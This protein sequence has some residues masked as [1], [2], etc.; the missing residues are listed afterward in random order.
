MTSLRRANRARVKF[1][2][3][4]ALA[5]PR[6]LV[7]DFLEEPAALTGCLPGF[8]EVRILEPGRSYSGSATITW[9][10][11]PL[12]VPIR[13]VWI[14]K[15]PSRG[16]LLRAHAQ[17]SGV[18]VGGEG[19]LALHDASGGGT[20]LQW[21]LTLTLPEQFADNKLLRQLVGQIAGRGLKS[22]LQCLQHSLGGPH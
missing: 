1:E 5:S 12:R 14:E 18:A 22:F 7:W 11:N 17:L 2:G 10:G 3:E 9:G 20:R 4:L 19:A 21:A 16:G 6:A 8:G 15:E 13:V